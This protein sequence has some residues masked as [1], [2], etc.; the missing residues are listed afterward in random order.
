MIN[1]RSFPNNL[2]HYLQHRNITYPPSHTLLTIPYLS[3]NHH[4]SFQHSYY[5]KQLWTAIIILITKIKVLHNH[6]LIQVPYIKSNQCKTNKIKFHVTIQY[7]QDCSTFCTNNVNYKRNKTPINIRT[8]NGS[9]TGI[10][11]IKTDQHPIH[12]SEMNIPYI[13]TDGITI[14]STYFVQKIILHFYS[15]YWKVLLIHQKQ[16][17]PHQTLPIIWMKWTL[18]TIATFTTS[19]RLPG[20][21]NSHHNQVQLYISIVSYNILYFIF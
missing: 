13:I 19:T 15:M 21:Y 1:K 5:A 10:Y 6:T 14:S 8:K 11:N 12:H 17:T 2:W 3:P 18:K 4:T 16:W 9:N 7:I 20:T